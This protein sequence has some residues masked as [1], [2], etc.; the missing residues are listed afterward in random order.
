[1]CYIAAEDIAKAKEMDL[2][3]YLRNYEPQELVHELRRYENERH[4]KYD[5]Q[6]PRRPRRE[7]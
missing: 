7:R 1:M 2:L 6:A 3:T 5:Y 4:Y